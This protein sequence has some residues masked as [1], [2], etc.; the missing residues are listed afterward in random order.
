MILESKVGAAGALILTSLVGMVAGAQAAY[1]PSTL[2]LSVLG[3]AIALLLAIFGW[4]LRQ[5]HRELREFVFMARDDHVTLHGVKG[6]GG[7]VRQVAAL[8]A[9]KISEHRAR[10]IM[11]QYV[12]DFAQLVEEARHGGKGPRGRNL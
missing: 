12:G 2:L 7:L 5:I 6:V 10:G 1:D 9:E 11:T 3:G 4:I 8:D